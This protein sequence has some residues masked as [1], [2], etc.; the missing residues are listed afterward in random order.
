MGLLTRTGLVRGG[1]LTTLM[2]LFE[3]SPIRQVVHGQRI[4]TSTG[5]RRI[6]CVCSKVYDASLIQVSVPYCV[7]TDDFLPITTT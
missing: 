2:V 5:G 7:L 3:D 1:G 6:F 4:D